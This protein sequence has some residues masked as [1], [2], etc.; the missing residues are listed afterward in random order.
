MNEVKVLIAEFADKVAA[1]DIEIYNEFSLQHELGIYLR[2]KLP[3]KKIQFERNVSF[4]DSG[5]TKFVKNEIDIVV[6]S[7]KNAP[8][9]AIELK[10]P[11]GKERPD[12]MFEFC[13][14][15][16]FAE[17][18]K[19][20]AGFKETYAVIF[21]DD[22]LCYESKRKAKNK[23]YAYFRDQKR[24]AGKIA[25]MPWKKREQPIQ[26]SGCY[27]ICWQTVTD[28]MKYAVIQAQ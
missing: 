5:K 22:R 25:R 7:D 4:F 12:K 1:G 15:V 9:V 3:A 13:K 14:D 19:R 2:C 28:K 20:Y 10:F 6:Y 16:K 8:D 24:L 23:I 26:L 17:Q 11:R 18:L 27:T 21:T